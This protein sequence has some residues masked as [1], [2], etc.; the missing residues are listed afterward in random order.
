MQGLTAAATAFTNRVI[1]CELS[2]IPDNTH[3]PGRGVIRGG[4][5]VVLVGGRI[6]GVVPG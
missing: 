2:G 5:V 4:D 1:L 3:H 6:D